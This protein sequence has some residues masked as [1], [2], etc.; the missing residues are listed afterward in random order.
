MPYTD[1]TLVCPD[2]AGQL[3]FATA[4]RDEGSDPCLQKGP[5]RCPS[6]GQTHGGEH[7]G[8]PAGIMTWVI[9]EDKLGFIKPGNDSTNDIVRVFTQN[10][11]LL[12]QAA[13][14]TPEQHRELSRPGFRGDDVDRLLG[15][16]IGRGGRRVV[17]LDGHGSRWLGRITGTRWHRSGRVWFVLNCPGT[18]AA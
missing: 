7:C 8:M 3:A 10:G 14:A 11:A 4:E 12:A 15:Y 18:A 5:R 6:C 16:Y 1:K 13:P 9:S 17:L 2:C